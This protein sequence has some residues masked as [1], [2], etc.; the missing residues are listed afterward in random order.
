MIQVLEYN[1]IEDLSRIQTI[2][3]ELHS[4][5]RNASFF[6]S[7]EWLHQYLI[8]NKQVKIKV[9]SVSLAG[10]IIGIVPLVIKP[11]QTR[12]GTVRA[13]TYPLDSWGI[14][15]S[16]I[17]PNPAATMATAMRYLHSAK[18]HW[19]ILDL[20]YI[21]EFGSDVGRTKNA[22]RLSGFQRLERLWSET[23]LLKMK[24]SW[25]EVCSSLPAATLK[26]YQ[27]SE[28][29]LSELENIEFHRYRPERSMAINQENHWEI[30]SQFEDM[31]RQ[32][33]KLCLGMRENVTSDKDWKFLRCVHEAAV[34]NGK[35]DLCWLT[36]NDKVISVSYNYHHRG[37]FDS[38]GTVYLK[39]AGPEAANVLMGRMIEDGFDR[40]DSAYY[41]NHEKSLLNL[42]W[43]NSIASSHR[44]S[45]FPLLAPRS[46]LLRMYQ[47]AF[48]REEDSHSR[49]GTEVMPAVTQVEPSE[50]VVQ[51][52]SRFKVVG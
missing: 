47:W 50:T 11:V 27:K 13:L 43:G 22:L 19:E 12:L 10:K 37:R 34:Q 7:W 23:S 1:S 4:Q 45:H 33:G 26:E 36:Q 35:L 42:E 40:F 3:R 24:G 31:S 16:S 49:F 2:W 38:L 46:Q 52:E 14:H 30:F 17:G 9:L 41:M 18:R 20:R 6:Q 39:S 51:D 44:Y 21:D 28:A 48:H 29:K 8:H 15:Y 32:S 25:E 5:T